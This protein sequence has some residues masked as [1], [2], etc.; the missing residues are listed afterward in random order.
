M[1]ESIAK[2]EIKGTFRKVNSE[3]D[4]FN[5][6]ALAGAKTRISKKG[7]QSYVNRIISVYSNLLLLHERK[8]WVTYVL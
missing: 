6:D 8:R 5:E 2:A 3:L 4:R 1:H 7:I